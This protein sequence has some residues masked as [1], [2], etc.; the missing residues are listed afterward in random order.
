MGVASSYS[1]APVHGDSRPNV[2]LWTLLLDWG[3]VLAHDDFRLR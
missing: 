1:S 2:K 3:D